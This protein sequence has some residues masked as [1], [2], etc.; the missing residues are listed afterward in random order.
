MSEKLQ[1]VLAA[2]GL[3]SRREIERW[4]ADG[5]ISVNGKEAK[6]GLRVT[7][8][9]SIKVDGRIIELD[10]QKETRVILYNK[11][12]G[13]ICTRDDPEGRPTVF[14]HL[15]NIRGG[16]WICIG[17]LDYNTSGL[18]LFTNNGE[19]AHKLMHPSAAI[20]REYAVRIF[21]PV[22]SE[23]VKTL[24]KGVELDDGMARFEDVVH[25]GGQGSNQWFHVVVTE[26]RNRVVR[27]LWESQDLVVSR[28]KRVRFGPV[29]LGS[30]PKQGHCVELKGKELSKLKGYLEEDDKEV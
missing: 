25:S 14:D 19:L 8:E 30:M 7:H 27:R 28:L 17:R 23:T 1:K 13:E 26:G 29:I 6:L 22:T 21:G 11:P 24:T 18:L 15:P 4:I 2:A 20:E 16:R 9:D 3:A 5:R 12:E 10:S